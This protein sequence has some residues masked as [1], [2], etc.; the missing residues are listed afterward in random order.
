M[1]ENT[2]REF[3]EFFKR[4]D[5]F[6]LGVCNGCQL[7]TRIKSLIPGAEHWPTFVD[8]TSQQF[9]GRFSMVKVEENSNKPSVFFHGMNGSTLPVVV[10]HGEG[11]AKFP[12]P[13]SL[14]ELT[15]SGMIPLR[16][17]DNRLGVT[18]QYPY[19]PN[20]SPGGVAG[21]STK[22]GRFVAMMPHPERTVLADVA[23]FVP[24]EAVEEWGEFGP[25]VRIFRSA[26]RWVG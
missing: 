10:S 11:R 22:D 1:H 14:Q 17:V 6:A 19:N 12:S 2:R 15:N 5:T 21:V 23:S 26:R 18:E 3:T 4:P 24:R 8:N 9:E 7:L 13:N 25:W 20:G 16:Y